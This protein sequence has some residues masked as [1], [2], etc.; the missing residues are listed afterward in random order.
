MRVL[1]TGG[2]TSAPIDD[3]RTITN[4]STGRFSAQI[5]EA[6][7]EAG[8]SVVHL[9]APAALLPF[10]R[11]ASFDPA[12]EDFDAEVRRLARLRDRWR[13]LA[14]GLEA[15]ALPSGTVAEY[16]DMLRSIIL[17][18]RPDVVLLAMAVSDYAPV[19]MEGKLSSDTPEITL[20]LNRLPKVIRSVR[21]WAPDAYLV[22]FKLLSGVDPAVLI[23]EAAEAT[24]I[25]RVDMTVANDLRLLKSGQHT[26]HLVRNDQPVETVGPGGPIARQLVDRVR[27]W[28]RGRLPGAG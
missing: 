6:F 16:S 25:N 9:H 11:E 24:I 19:A 7:L 5:S 28:A 15:V 10:R 20:R 3:V 8:D 26:V 4:A 22:G 17:E 12:C 18:R 1:V 23:H 2:G 21:D 27:E 13:E 14:P